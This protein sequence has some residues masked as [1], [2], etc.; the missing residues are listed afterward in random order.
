VIRAD[1]GSEVTISCAAEADP[2]SSVAS[3]P[4]DVSQLGTRSMVDHVGVEVI[5]AARQE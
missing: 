2:E 3:A 4:E 1:D 5:L